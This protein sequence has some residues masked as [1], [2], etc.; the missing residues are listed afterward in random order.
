[1]LP[2]REG[3][4]PVRVLRWQD[5][6]TIRRTA[7]SSWCFP[8]FAILIWH[9]SLSSLTKARLQ[10]SDEDIKQVS[11]PGTHEKRIHHITEPS[12]SSRKPIMLF[13][14]FRV[15]L[16]ASGNTRSSLPLITQHCFMIRR[17]TINPLNW[18]VYRSVSSQILGRAIQLRTRISLEYPRLDVRV[19]KHR[20]SF[21][22]SRIPC[23]SWSRLSVSDSISTERVG[24]ILFSGLLSLLWVV[25]CSIWFFP[26]ASVPI[27]RKWPDNH[28]P[29]LL[30]LLPRVLIFAAKDWQLYCKELLNWAGP[31]S[32]PRHQLSIFTSATVH[33]PP[34]HPPFISREGKVWNCRSRIDGSF[35]L[36][37]ISSILY[38]L[39]SRS[40]LK[41]RMSGRFQVW[42]F[43]IQIEWMDEPV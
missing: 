11:D 13:F 33:H 7:R 43:L 27:I 2:F 1:V 21:C 6:R 26:S 19:F 9:V 4:S 39:T 16:L 28:D 30:M 20:D 32:I 38:R 18:P 31:I 12:C 5:S 25:K 3:R 36:S 22:Q 23:L 42:L 14:V 29:W 24:L 35:S 34:W 10:A 41:K 17:R 8:G 15:W 40:V 37:W